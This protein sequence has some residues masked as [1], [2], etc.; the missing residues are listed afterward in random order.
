MNEIDRA[1]GEAPPQLKYRFWIDEFPIAIFQDEHL[2][3]DAG[4]LE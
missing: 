4:R 1:A 2:D 3:I